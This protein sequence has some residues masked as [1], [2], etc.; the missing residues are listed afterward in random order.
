[1]TLQ[2]DA[3][4]PGE[5]PSA[6]A[7]EKGLDLLEA[8]ADEPVG[9]TQK[10][11]AERVSRSVGEIFR[12]LSVLEQRGYVHRDLETNQYTLTLKLF[13]LS[14]RYP[15]MR[16]LQQAALQSMETLADT[17][18]YSCHLMAM[19]G[20]HMMVITHSEPRNWRMGW[21]VKLGA[22]FELSSHYAS[23]RILAAFQQPERQQEMIRA[24][25]SYDKLTDAA[26]VKARLDKIVASGYD[27][28]SSETTSGVID[29]SFPIVNPFHQAVAALTVAFVGPVDGTQTP[30][31]LLPQ[32]AAT[33][34]EISAAIGG[35]YQPVK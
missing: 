21:S 2:D 15:P 29:I 32:V 22:P 33:A 6:P 35:T 4:A 12:M 8:L 18:G 34:A 28:A 31:D 20:H 9:L 19:S 5:R 14:N 17:I 16:R 30:Q 10:V 13:E 26:P 23:A 11:L 3:V 1:M 27:V 7:L 24:M 25:V